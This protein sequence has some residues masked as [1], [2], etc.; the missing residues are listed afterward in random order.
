ME[1]GKGNS[2]LPP[3]GPHFLFPFFSLLQPTSRRRGTTSARASPILPKQL[4]AGSRAPTPL[5]GGTALSGS[6]S[7]SSPGRTRAA[8][9][10]CARFARGVPFSPGFHPLNTDPKPRNPP[11]YP[12][13]QSSRQTR[14]KPPP[15]SAASPI[16]L[17]S[18]FE[19]P[20]ATCRASFSSCEVAETLPSRST[21]F[22]PLLT[23]AGVLSRVAVR[24]PPSQA[25][26]SL[27]PTSYLL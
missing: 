22:Y 21:A 11:S 13:L 7:T 3:R 1:N 24:L 26:P 17:R 16:R 20:R 12:E 5:P 6:F 9:Q 8:L 27:S 10:P 15:R 2:P 25:H 14:P 4:T 18:A 19:P 23:L